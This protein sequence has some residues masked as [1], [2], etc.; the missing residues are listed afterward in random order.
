[1]GLLEGSLTRGV[2]GR[3]H[4]L[5]IGSRLGPDHVVAGVVEV[6]HG[7][8]A[9]AGCREDGLIYCVFLQ[10]SS[11]SARHGRWMAVHRRAR[12]VGVKREALVREV[13]RD[14]VQ[15]RSTAAPHPTTPAAIL[16]RENHPRW[17]ILMWSIRRCS[18]IGNISVWPP[19][20]LQHPVRTLLMRI[21]VPQL[22]VLKKGKLP[23]IS[24]SK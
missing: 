18:T 23:I 19:V 5:W 22:C 20:A 14:E 8:P 7:R 21:A 24:F 10:I 13:C 12:Q 16:V 6:G 15:P 17:E 4:V 1:M 3:E 11:G 2:G 9:Q